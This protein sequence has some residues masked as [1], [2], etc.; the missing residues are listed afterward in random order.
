MLRPLL[1][2]E[3]AILRQ[4]GLPYIDRPRILPHSPAR[5]ERPLFFWLN[6]LE[7]PCR[8]EFT[9]RSTDHKMLWPR[10][11]RWLLRLIKR[12]YGRARSAGCSTWSQDVTAAREALAAQIDHKML[13]PRE[14]LWLLRLIKRCYGRARSAGCFGLIARC[15]GRARS[16]GCFRLITKRC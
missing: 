2:P 16:A 9:G 8:P 4:A 14:K 1:T 11:K 5:T 12:C 10:E 7:R 13:W 6:R 15:S 3:M